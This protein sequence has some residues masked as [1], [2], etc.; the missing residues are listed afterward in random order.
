MFVWRGESDEERRERREKREMKEERGRG[1]CVI[2]GRGDDGWVR[3][4]AS[5]YLSS[6][7]CGCSL[8]IVSSHLCSYKIADIIIHEF[9]Y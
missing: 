9:I 4:E 8:S 5:T 6:A 1:V 3:R 7:R 2:G